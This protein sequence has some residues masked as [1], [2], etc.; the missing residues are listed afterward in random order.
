MYKVKIKKE[1][2]P[3]VLRN[4]RRHLRKHHAI[5][6]PFGQNVR[7]VKLTE[8]QLPYLMNLLHDPP[9]HMR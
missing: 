7:Y 3:V 1:F 4:I 5:S 9:S 8:K 2:N 6:Y